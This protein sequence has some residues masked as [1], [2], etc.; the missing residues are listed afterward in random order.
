MLIAFLIQ[1][2]E[3]TLYASD[4]TSTQI[5]MVNI[6]DMVPALLEHTPK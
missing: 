3:W 5:T 6:S 4:C 1:S 2:F